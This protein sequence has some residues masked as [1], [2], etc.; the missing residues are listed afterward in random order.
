MDVSLSVAPGEIVRA[1]S[2]RVISYE[3]RISDV[4]YSSNCGGHSQSAGDIS[5]WGAVPYFSGV[6]DGSA[7]L[8]APDSPW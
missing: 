4:L 6:K 3:G 1:T 7:E 8:P 5:G 2:G